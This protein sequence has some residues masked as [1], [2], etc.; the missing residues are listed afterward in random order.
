MIPFF[1]VLHLV[2]VLHSRRDLAPN[3]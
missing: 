3:S 2:S 1:A